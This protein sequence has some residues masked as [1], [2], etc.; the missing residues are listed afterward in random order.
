MR[1]GRLP[2]APGL[3]RSSPPGA[4]WTTL[5][6]G[7][8]STFVLSFAADPSSTTLYAGT[9]ADLYR[10]RDSGA[11]WESASHGLTNSFV[12]VL[13]IH[14]KDRRT[15]YAGTNCGVFKT[16]DGGRHW[17]AVRLVAPDAAPRS[18]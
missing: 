5:S 10:S 11:T 3:F 18:E 6:R 2:V 12:S 8:R 4:A 1:H 9:A 17:S 16:T 7:M 14:P 15:L 13:A